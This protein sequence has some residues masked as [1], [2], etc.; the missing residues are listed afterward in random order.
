MDIIS[1]GEVEEGVHLMP[2]R[3]EMVEVVEEVVLEVVQDRQEV[4][5]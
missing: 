5:D 1:S 4:E 2:Y 3:V